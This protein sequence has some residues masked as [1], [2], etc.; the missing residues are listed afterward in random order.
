MTKFALAVTLLGG[1]L[2]FAGPSLSDNLPSGVGLSV[3]VIGL[4]MTSLAAVSQ[5]RSARP[6][7]A[8]FGEAEWARAADGYRLVYPRARHRLVHVTS[9]VV[10]MPNAS[11]HEEVL[12]DKRVESDGSVVLGAAR[13]FVGRVVVA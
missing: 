5:Y 4:L 8:D 3:G 2:S 10:F 6:F 12:C 13:P 1:I 11:G 7:V 9:I